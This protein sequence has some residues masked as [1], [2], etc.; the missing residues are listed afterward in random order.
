MRLVKLDNGKTFLIR[1]TPAELPIDRFTIHQKYLVQAAGIGSTMGDIERHF[2]LLDK[3]ITAG[4]IQEAATERYNL[5]INLYLCLNE[6]NI[7]HLA[8]AVLVDAI[9]D[10]PVTDYSEQGLRN[11]AQ[12]LAEA[13][14]T[15]GQLTDILSEVKKKSIL[16]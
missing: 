8:F 4:K 3:F 9:E 15:H 7:Q 12:K 1:E 6:V 13:G 14:L 10:V 2:S 11:I 16:L 5:H